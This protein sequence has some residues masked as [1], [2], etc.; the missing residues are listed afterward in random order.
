[1]RKYHTKLLNR[2]IK[3]LCLSCGYTEIRKVKDGL[4][5]RCPRCGSR[6]LTI[7][8]SRDLVEM[9]FEK[10]R[11]KEELTRRE[12][13]KFSTLLSISQLLKLKPNIILLAVATPGVNLNLAVSLS[14]EYNDVNSL[15]RRLQEL[16]EN[17][18]KIRF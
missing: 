2:R 14:L 8:K 16:D 11:R 5:D 12:R 17:Y 7:T 3:W 6:H 18:S 9:L 4:L 1:M 15:M 13:Q 10:M